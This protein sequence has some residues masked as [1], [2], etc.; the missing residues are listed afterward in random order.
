M[1][2]INQHEWTDGLRWCAVCGT[3]REQAET[4]MGCRDRNVA[5]EPQRR[6]VA[7]EDTATISTRLAEL[8]AERQAAWNRAQE[9]E[10]T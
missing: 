8:R 6:T 4:G 9:G 5:P 7:C 3:S 10:V 2:R 1:P